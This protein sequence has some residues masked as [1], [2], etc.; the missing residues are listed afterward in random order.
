MSSA[1]STSTRTRAGPSPPLLNLWRAPAGT[2]TVSPGPATIVA[3]AEPELHRALEHVEALLLLGVHV[4][5]G[6]APVGRELQLELEQRAVGVR[7]GLQEL[8]ALP[9]D[10]VVDD[11]SG[12]GP[13]RVLLEVCLGD[14]KAPGSRP[15]RVVGRDDD[16]VS[17]PRAILDAPS[18]GGRV[19][20]ADYGR[21]ASSARNRR[22]WSASCA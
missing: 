15:R 16:S 13:F 21:Y 5:A 18:G 12:D 2:T 4:R 9:A 14:L 22:S 3:Q 8:D 10:G 20:L 11:L 7:G 1:G 6:H 17:A 19:L